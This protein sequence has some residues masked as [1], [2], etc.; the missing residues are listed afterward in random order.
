MN[1]LYTI[2]QVADRLKVHR[3]TVYLWKDKG[4]LKAQRIGS[5]ALRVTEQDLEDFIHRHNNKRGE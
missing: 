4:L 1:E 5:R 3:N 2:Q